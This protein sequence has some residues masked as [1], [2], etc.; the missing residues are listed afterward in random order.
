M[1]IY[2]Y[3]SLA[4]QIVIDIRHPDEEETKPRIV[5]DI[6][7]QKIPFYGLNKIFT[8]LDSNKQYFLYCQKGVMSQLHAANLKDAG[9]V[10]VGVY[11]PEPVSACAD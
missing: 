1:Q 2:H 3:Q 10:N 8:T 5:D 7:I 4:N 6:E 11:R 9:H